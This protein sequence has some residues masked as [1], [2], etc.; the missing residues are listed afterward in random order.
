MVKYCLFRVCLNRKNVK[1]DSTYE[2]RY[3]EDLREAI[4]EMYYQKSCDR[5]LYNAYE[6]IIMEVINGDKIHYNV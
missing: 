6:Y 5:R 1:I 4:K 2:Y 3:F